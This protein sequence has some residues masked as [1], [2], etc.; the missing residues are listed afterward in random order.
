[1]QGTPAYMAPEVAQG[2]AHRG[3]AADV[4][5]LGVLLYNLLTKGALCAAR[6]SVVWGSIRGP[7]GGSVRCAG[8]RAWRIARGESRAANRPRVFGPLVR[9]L[10]SLSQRAVRVL[11]QPLLGQID[12]RAAAQHHALDAQDPGQPLPRLP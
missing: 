1:M 11:A 6:P 3:A 10:P 7:R 12:G 8:G 9:R 2:H 5:S 4:W